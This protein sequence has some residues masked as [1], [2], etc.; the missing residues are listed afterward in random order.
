MVK[1]FGMILLNSQAEALRVDELE[2][3][4]LLDAGRECGWIPRGARATLALPGSDLVEVADYRTCGQQVSTDD[5]RELARALR[6]NPDGLA[7]RLRVTG[8][9]LEQLLRFL[10][11]GG[12]VLTSDLFALSQTLGWHSH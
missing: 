6:R 9:R 2:W 4:H 5:A 7:G 8:E 12:F 11:G 10:E 1:V 3:S